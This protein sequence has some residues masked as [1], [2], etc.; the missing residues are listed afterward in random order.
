MKLDVLSLDGKKAGT[1]DLADDVFGL[2]PRSDILHRVVTWQLAKRQAGTHKTQTRTEVSVTGKKSI[3]QK[4]S[5]G[6]RHGAR[7]ASQYVGGQKAHGPVVRSHAHSLNKKI[8]TLGLKHAL[9]AKA[10]AGELIV[11]EAAAVAEPKTKLVKD[12]LHKLGAE[13][14]LVIAGET[15]DENFAR[16]AANLAHVDVLPV[17]GANVYD[18]LRREK[19]ILTKDA[20]DALHARFDG[21]ALAKLRAERAAAEDGEDERRAAERKARKLARRAIKPGSTPGA[22]KTSEQEAA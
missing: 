11:V 10:G 1:V 14:V 2:E 15:L 9:S 20:V 17:Q 22:K 19:L 18:I 4:G 13:K 5:G 8:R 16:A 12:A 21:S 6:A 7:N 3:R